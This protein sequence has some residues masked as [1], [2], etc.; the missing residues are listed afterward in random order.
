M[1]IGNSD[2]ATLTS[3]ATAGGG[4]GGI[5]ALARAIKPKITVARVAVETMFIGGTEA[6]LLQLML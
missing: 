6:E 2:G 4:G 1:S 3:S 5:I